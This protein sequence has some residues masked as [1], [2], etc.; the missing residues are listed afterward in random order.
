MK[1][2]I[3]KENETELIKLVEEYGRM[4][5]LVS[6]ENH[7]RE[8]EEKALQYILNFFNESQITLLSQLEKEIEGLKV[9]FSDSIC[10]ASH[11]G[12]DASCN[13]GFNQAVKAVLQIIKAHK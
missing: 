11:D 7:P 10:Y 9:S 4:S 3:I 12:C 2:Q 6:E 8:R 5:Y 13:E 1:N